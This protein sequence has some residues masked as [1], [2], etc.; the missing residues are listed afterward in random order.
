MVPVIG[1]LIDELPIK[2]STARAEWNSG[3]QYILR[4]L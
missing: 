1:I 2:Q 4:N 3:G